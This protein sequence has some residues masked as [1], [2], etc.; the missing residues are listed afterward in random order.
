[1][2]TGAIIQARTSSTRLP[3]KI[4]KSLP[5]GSGISV[6]AQVLRRLRVCENLDTVIVA[7][8]TSSADNEIV[9]ISNRENTPCFRGDERNVLSRYYLA[10][11]EHK[12]DIIVRITSDC[13]CIDPEIVDSVI[14]KHIETNVDYTSNITSRTFPRGMD[15][16]VV[17][18][19]TLEFVN[20]QAV[21]KSEREHVFTFIRASKP[22]SFKIG[23]I[24][25]ES[26][27]LKRP[28]I[29]LVLDEEKDYA[30][31]C[32][33]YD[34]LYTKDSIFLLTDIISLFNQKPWLKLINQGIKQKK[35][36]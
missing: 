28:D 8:T 26:A 18:F 21:R 22:E 31:L 15:T 33:V 32:A 12:L 35:C 7:T 6:L 13:P 2:K 27:Y 16:E 9:K 20:S 23:L 25:A 34:Y 10:A 14:K 29:R 4:L 30:L 11:K 3:D 36:T 5:Y 17:S 1:M 24:E 19:D